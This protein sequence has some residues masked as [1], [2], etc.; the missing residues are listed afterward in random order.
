M[1]IKNKLLF[2]YI[3]IVLLSLILS[4]ISF[5]YIFRFYTINQT[6]TEMKKEGELLAQT[7]ALEQN[8]ETI[9]SKLLTR[10][11]LKQAGR[12]LDTFVL[13]M[14]KTDKVLY[15]N[16]DAAARQEILRSLPNRN[17]ASQSYLI[18]RVSV[19]TPTSPIGSIIMAARMDEVNALNAQIY[20][21]EIIS[22]LIAALVAFVLATLFSRQ[23]TRA[24][25][26]LGRRMHDF[27]VKKPYEKTTL[28]TGDEIED[29]SHCFDNL[30]LRLKDYDEGQ[31]VFMQNTSHEFK[32]PLMSIQGYAEAIRDGLVD[33]EELN[34]SLDIIIEESQRLK[35]TV[36]EFILLSKLET[37]GDIYRLQ[38][39]SLA[40]LFDELTRRL[41]PLADIKSVQLSFTAH[42]A[43]V[44]SF[45]REKMFQALYNVLDN[46]IKYAS[47]QVS[48]ESCLGNGAL[49]IN[50]KDD[51]PGFTPGEEETVFKRF[52]KGPHGG[53][54]IGLAISKT[55]VEGHHGSIIAK[56]ASHG[57]AEFVI[58]LPLR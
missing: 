35:K 39:V 42:G 36:D 26:L 54:G 17:T 33:G 14:D 4:S 28:K 31:R 50:I 18:E 49:T 8:S 43:L 56:N 38:K 10:Q 57:G 15:T 16:S 5:Q 13:V 41:Q 40:E 25:D 34:Q 53:S 47:N 46:C 9:G 29:L 27:S 45:D 32:T 55:V 21:S 52:Y 23:L 2:S 44:F 19:N 24:I 12:F 7:I 22:F 30:A 11:R 51:G 20:K 37:P 1:K 58:T 48:M 3:I 6:R